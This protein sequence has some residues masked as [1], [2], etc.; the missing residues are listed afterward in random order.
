MPWRTTDLISLR[1]EFVALALQAGVNMSELC[2]RFSISRKTGYKWLRRYL[3]EDVPGLIDRSRRPRRIVMHIA[4]T[5]E[6]AIVAL[7]HRHPC[8]GARKIRRRLQASG[9]A[10]VPACS[11]IT[12]VLHRHDLIRP[13][14]LGGRRDWQR[15]AHPVPNSLW[16]MDFKR[17][18]RSLAGSA[19][20]LTV[21][22]DCS[23]FSLCLR[24]LPNQQ[25]ATVQDAL[26]ATFRRYGL[27][28]QL[29]V[30]NGSPWGSDAE[31]IYTPLG[32]WL[33]RLGVHVSH[34]HPYHPQTLG[35]DERF[36]RTLE[37]E[38]LRNRQ[39]QDLPHL[40]RAFD[41][42]RHLYN[43]ER[44]HEALA[45]D[46]PA[47]R[48]QPSLRALPEHLPAIEYPS[49]LQVRKVQQGGVVCFQGQTLRIGKAFTGYPV[50]LQLTQIDGV[51][52]VLFCHRRI[53]QVDLRDDS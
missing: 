48:Y 17:P 28:D 36:H 32:V 16:Q 3:G 23:R 22:D 53:A 38:V 42:W 43:F 39:W 5:V 50:G 52:D 12:V 11:T 1:Q 24:A 34:S 15:F 25:T 4:P 51:L 49:G 45:L 21:L 2:C 40:Q 13:E 46:V 19:H 6:E 18:V 8:W 9:V 26:T 47:T 33:I 10:P 7:R 37:A 31:H 44:P 29:L 20:P 27:P 14:A 35:K 30:D 41:R